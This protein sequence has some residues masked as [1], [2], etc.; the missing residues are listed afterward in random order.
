MYCITCFYSAHSVNWKSFSP[1]LIHKFEPNTCWTPMSLVAFMDK[2]P[3][4][5]EYLKITIGTLLPLLQL[6]YL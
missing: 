1:Y 5:V 4:G 3:K 6:V 2:R